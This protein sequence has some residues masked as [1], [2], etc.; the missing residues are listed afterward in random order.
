MIYLCSLS[1]RCSL[2]LHDLLL[3]DSSHFLQDAI[4][5]LV[6]GHPSVRW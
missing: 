6:S 4:D 1:C 2:F 3:E 5:D